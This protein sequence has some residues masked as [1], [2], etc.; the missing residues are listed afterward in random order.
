MEVECTT[1]ATDVLRSGRS[2]G[3]LWA[4]LQRVCFKW[5]I[6]NAFVLTRSFRR[7]TQCTF[8]RNSDVCKAHPDLTWILQ[9]T[10]NFNNFMAELIDSVLDVHTIVLGKAAKVVDDFNPGVVEVSK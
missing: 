10:T 4:A 2:A 9:A 6:I 7:T 3:H 8:T 5:A 1:N